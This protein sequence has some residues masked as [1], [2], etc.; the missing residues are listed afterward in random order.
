MDEIKLEKLQKFLEQLCKFNTTKNELKLEELIRVAIPENVIIYSSDSI[1]NDGGNVELKSLYITTQDNKDN[2]IWIKGTQF[3][4]KGLSYYCVQVETEE[5]TL[6]E[7]S[8]PIYA[9]PNNIL[10]YQTITGLYKDGKYIEA[11]KIST[12]NFHLKK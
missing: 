1:G 10:A 7:G 4:L 5:G 3:K 12:I 11:D 8:W 9:F 6:V 2:L